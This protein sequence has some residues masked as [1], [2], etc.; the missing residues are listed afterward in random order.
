MQFW[1][2]LGQNLCL[3]GLSRRP[4]FTIEKF[5]DVT[6]R[7]MRI[8]FA[9]LAA[10]GLL[11]LVLSSGRVAPKLAIS[12]ISV[13][14]LTDREPRPEVGLVGPLPAWIPLPESGSVI[15]AG[16]YPPQPPFGAAA[17]V[18]LEIDNSAEAFLT[19]YQ[20]RLDQAGFSMRRLPTPFNLIIDRP[21]ALFEADERQ[22]GH[23][24]YITMR[25]TRFAQLTF[26][27]PPAP[28]M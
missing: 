23:V 17:T 28:R 15:S 22:G 27:E 4:A 5:G 6:K 11:A 10:V 24:I 12:G 19:A 1:G 8:V 7:S 26:W 16:L 2:G 18:T 21:D 20:S 13:T 9:V 25:A 14:T 3:F